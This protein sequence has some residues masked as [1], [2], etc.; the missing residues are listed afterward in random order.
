MVEHWLTPYFLDPIDTEKQIEEI[1][2]EED[3]LSEEMKEQ[4]NKEKQMA[5]ANLQVDAIK[6][7]K[8]RN[9]VMGELLR[10]KGF[11]WLATS[12]DLI[13]AWQQAGNVLRIE[14]EGK[15]MCLK[16]QLWEGT[17]VEPEVRKVK[18]S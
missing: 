18:V 9:T 12:N 6:K 1:F 13:G 10:S 2:E 16:P 5:I 14:A 17:E 11:L 8:E 3:K 7:Q 4:L 15:W